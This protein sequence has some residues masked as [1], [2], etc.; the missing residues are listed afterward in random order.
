MGVP[1][2]PVL[3]ARPLD[4]AIELQFA[5]PSDNLYPVTQ[6]QFRQGESGVAVTPL[7]TYPQEATFTRGSTGYSAS[8]TQLEAR[9]VA[10]NAD[11]R[12]A[13]LNARTPLTSDLPHIEPSL[14]D[15][16]IRQRFMIQA[17]N[18]WN[19]FTITMPNG[20]D[21]GIRVILR[22]SDSRGKQGGAVIGQAS[23]STYTPSSVTFNSTSIS[24]SNWGAAAA[25][26]TWYALIEAYLIEGGGGSRHDWQLS[27]RNSDNTSSTP[28]YVNASGGVVDYVPITI[29]GG[30]TYLAW[31]DIPNP[32]LGQKRHILRNLT[33]GNTYHLQVRARNADGLSEP[34]SEQSA[35]PSADAAASA[36]PAFR[37]TSARHLDKRITANLWLREFPSHKLVTEL[38]GWRDINWVE[39]WRKAGRAT[40]T[41]QQG[42]ISRAQ[43]ASLASRSYAVEM[44][45]HTEPPRRYYAVIDEVALS[46]GIFTSSFNTHPYNK[47]T[48]VNGYLGQVD[49]ADQATTTVTANTGII[50]AFRTRHR[51]HFDS[52]LDTDTLR[53]QWAA[54]QLIREADIHQTQ[55]DQPLQQ[56]DRPATVQ[57]TLRPPLSILNDEWSQPN[58]DG[59]AKHAASTAAGTYIKAYIDEMATQIGAT[60]TKVT[61]GL[62]I[63]LP[64]RWKNIYNAVQEA[65]EQGEVGIACS[66]DPAARTLTYNIGRGN[67][68][69]TGANFTTFNASSDP[70]DIR[71]G[72]IANRAIWMNPT[73]RE[74][75]A[76]QAL[77]CT[78]V[79]VTGSIDREL[80]VHP[81]FSDAPS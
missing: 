22:Q 53:A 1:E 15:Y 61:D 51:V 76:V 25:D 77:Q 41:F 49:A 19:R 54:A 38:E 26:G 23:Y 67:D 5:T 3:A 57:L 4:G 6:W 71:L 30:I 79:G 11:S 66:F 63:T 60:A 31:A 2:Q 24:A 12:L 62:N 80:R 73:D 78:A 33:N 72:D 37:T 52:T 58:S 59:T 45:V 64:T 34:S 35:T 16:I 32:S 46:N 56:D 48:V 14:N 18:T 17:T 75:I 42:A 13:Q 44:V 7:H 68:R 10:A 43:V 70:L 50:S 74:A 28:G 9:C 36:Q 47:I 65:A 29:P 27:W 20:N 81:R 8:Q 69:T 39:E 40:I 21:D 55:V